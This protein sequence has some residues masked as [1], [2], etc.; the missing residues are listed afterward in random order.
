MTIG[1]V[2]R[3]RFKHPDANA[4]ITKLI[5]IYDL[6]SAKNV[7]NTDSLKAF[8]QSSPDYSITT[9]PRGEHLIPKTGLEAFNAI[10]CVL[11][12]LKVVPL[13]YF[14]TI[15]NAHPKVMHSKPNPIYHRDIQFKNL[16]K[17][18][19]SDKWFLIDWGDATTIPTYA[20]P[21]LSKD[22]HSPNVFHDNHGAEV[23]I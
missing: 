13:I 7:P 9:E 5:S 21:H 4:R 20:A 15:S 18:H 3:K 22:S 8:S 10:T 19:D 16:L 14:S 17:K 6:L 1:A 2:V 23:D 12:A 11:E